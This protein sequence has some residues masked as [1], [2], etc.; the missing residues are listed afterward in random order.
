MKE[1]VNFTRNYLNQLATDLKSWTSRNVLGET[2]PYRDTQFSKLLSR[3]EEGKSKIQSLKEE[4]R[5]LYSK[6]K[7][8]YKDN[9]IDKAK[10][11]LEDVVELDEDLIEEEITLMNTGDA[12]DTLTDTLVEEAYL[13]ETEEK[14]KIKSYL[15]R[16]E[17][18]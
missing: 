10:D 17:S 16:K 3:V 1:I 18:Y 4:R 11:T 6:A 8:L 7:D 12:Y 2:S 13:L 15:K 14:S 9:E 5:T